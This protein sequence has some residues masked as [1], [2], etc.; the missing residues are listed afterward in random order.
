MVTMSRVSTIEPALAPVLMSGLTFAG[1]DDVVV[2]DTA[3]YLR[4]SEARASAMRRK[5]E[6][7][8]GADWAGLLWHMVRH[9]LVRPARD[10]DLLMVLADAADAGAAAAVVDVLA[11]VTSISALYAE[12]G[13]LVS[14]LLLPGYNLVIDRLLW[15][16]YRD[17]H[18]VVL[19]RANE[20]S[21]DIQRA[22]WLVRA[23]AGE[24]IPAV[25][26]RSLVRALRTDMN[27]AGVTVTA[28]RGGRA[29]ELG[30]DALLELVVAAEAP[31]T[32]VSA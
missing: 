3:R 18:E 14:D 4:G 27:A 32:T 28:V 8:A 31:A 10:A 9:G 20:L 22:L 26:A 19:A 1:V 21:R 25:S 17:D 24:A 23:R 30:R 6:A 16:A 29:V 5:L 15:A 12:R 13:Y 7:A 2:C 11:G